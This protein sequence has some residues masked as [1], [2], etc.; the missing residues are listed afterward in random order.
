MVSDIQKSVREAFWCSRGVA[1]VLF[2]IW[3]CN[4]GH[5]LVIRTCFRIAFV[6]APN[7]MY[8]CSGQEL[9][10]CQIRSASFFI[11]SKREF[12]PMPSDLER[13]TS[14]TFVVL[15]LPRINISFCQ[16]AVEY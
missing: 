16:F 9:G 12:D 15:I 14:F 10:F 4:Q 1:A 2:L 5:D 11:R 6:L 7:L 8:R 3:E 13:D